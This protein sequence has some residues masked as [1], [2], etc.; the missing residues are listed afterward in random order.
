ML[1]K[2]LLSEV[3]R[4]GK[5]KNTPCIS[6]FRPE[7]MEIERPVCSQACT[8]NC[9]SSHYARAGDGRRIPGQCVE[10]LW[11]NGKMY[12]TEYSG[13]GMEVPPGVNFEKKKEVVL[14]E[15]CNKLGLDL[16]FRFVMQPWFIRCKQLGI[17]EIRG[18][19]IEPEDSSWFESFMYQLSRR[20]GLGAIFAD[21]HRRAMDELEGELP[22][23]LI[24]LGRE[25]EFDF[26]L[27]AHR[28]GRFYDGEPLPFWVI[29]AMMHVG[30]S[31]DPAIG[32]HQSSLMLAEF[33][34]A[35]R[36]LA[37]R[38]FRLLSQKVW[39]Y[40][41][42][43]DPT[44][45]HKAPVAIWSQHQHMLID[46][47]PLCDFAFP[48]LVRPFQSEDDW[49]NAE[50]IS[51]DLDLGLRLFAAVTGVDLTREEA[52]AIAER[53]FTLERVMLARAGRGRQMEE[54]LEPHFELPCPHDGTSIDRKGFSRLLDEYYA[55]RGWDLE[56]GW[57]RADKLR[58]LGLEEAIPE[59]KQR[60]RLLSNP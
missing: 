56:Y 13:G 57:P 41:D 26:G 49:R 37:L 1:L 23:E 52:T 25:Q 5:H 40:A 6:I 34:I 14:H 53:A 35:D 30:A 12:L 2:K 59:L 19:R 51:G 28:E 45:D 24:Q 31:R 27:P 58:E 10:P 50:D 3:L 54:T 47:L 36:E 4:A 38:Q 43:L 21:D 48:Q 20:E 8:F 9:G 39:G 7:G 29:S 15:L 55:A 46:S 42:A 22:E 16:W 32:T 11:R 18:I 60:R 17:N 44:L 33:L